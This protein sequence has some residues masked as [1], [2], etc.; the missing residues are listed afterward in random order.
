M[1]RIVAIYAVASLL[2]AGVTL[3]FVTPR[4]PAVADDMSMTTCPVFTSI[5][6][7][8]PM[9]PPESGTQYELTVTQNAMSCVQATTWAKKLVAEHIDGKP[10]MPSYPPLTAG[11]PGYACSGS[12][13]SAG[14]AWRGHCLK[15]GKAVI[16]PGF[17]WSNHSTL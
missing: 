13:D 1:K 9:Q 2:S 10:M 8:S 12:P 14:H 3:G 16:L 11:P 6:W 15:T 5:K 17:N 4:L 7:V